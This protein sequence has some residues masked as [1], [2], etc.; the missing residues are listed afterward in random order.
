M[1]KTHEVMFYTDG[2][3]TSVYLYEP[4]MGVKQYVEPIDELLDLGIDTVSYAVGDCSVLLYDSKVG[5]HWGHNV[6]LTDHDIWWRAAQNAKAM[7]ASGTDPLM[8]V[9]EH[10]Q[11][12]G[13]NFLPHLLL[14]MLHTPHDRVTNCRVADFTTE[15]PEWRVGEEPDYPQAQ[16]DN[17]E[18]LSFAVDEVRADRLAVVAE[19][20]G[21]YP[22][23]GIEL[24]MSDYAPFIGRAEVAEHTETLTEWMRAIR[25]VCDEAANAQGRAKR[26]V[27]RIGATLAGNKA[28]GMDVETWIKEGIVDAVIG[29]E[30]VG[31]FANDTT[32]L[33]D[34][35]EAAAGTRVRVLAGIE[36]ANHPEL[37]R[38]VVR[39]AAANAYA[40][41]AQ[42]VLF[43][44]YY[45]APKRYPYDD[46]ATGRLRFM[47]YPDLLAGFDKKYRLGLPYN[48]NT[49][50]SYGLA[51]Q[52]PAQLACDA[53]AHE[54]RL[55]VGDDVAGRAAV[56]EVWHCELR[57]LLQ[58]LTYADRIRLIW[59]GEEIPEEAWR[60]ADWTYQLRPRPDYAVDAYRLHVDLKQLQRLPLVG[61]NRLSAEILEKD[62]QLIH[63]VTLA[64]IDLIV[65]YLPHRNA[66]REDEEYFA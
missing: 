24:N 10:A 38:P 22:T 57:V 12:R 61:V 65:E 5:E 52:L 42:G 16:Y 13:F 56:G 43:H 36:S 7:I 19:L 28:M 6:D 30:V 25:Q 21:D 18:R 48:A 45:P 39:A 35:V 27:I 49:A 59:N 66:L 31:G 23:D 29:M 46:E 62:A 47:G 44:T 15:H 64:D 4:P 54:C 34:I 26:L 33:Q 51:E 40:A 2:R 11:R 3:H 58:H 50:A 8:L 32:G 60:K 63:P 1:S 41:G 37:S 53:P 20:V 17:P 55:E 9:C 14:N